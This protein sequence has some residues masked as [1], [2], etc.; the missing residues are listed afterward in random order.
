MHI[1]TTI[2]VIYMIVQSGKKRERCG[3]CTGCISVDCRKCVNCKDM[4]KYG[5]PRKRKKPCIERKCER[6]A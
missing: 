6:S 5:G 3:T 1:Y 2:L 4:Q